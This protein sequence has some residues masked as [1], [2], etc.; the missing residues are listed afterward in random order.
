MEKR[1]KRNLKIFLKNKTTVGG[2][3]KGMFVG[4]AG[5]NTLMRRRCKIKLVYSSLPCQSAFLRPFPAA[6]TSG[7]IS[8][9]RAVRASRD[10]VPSRAQRLNY[11]SIFFSFFLFVYFR[12]AGWISEWIS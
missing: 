6:E 7:T 2:Q 1:R 4:G 11:V 12:A 3:M 10:I 5:P 9:R 8:S